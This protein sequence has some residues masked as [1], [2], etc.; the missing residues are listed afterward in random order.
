MGNVPEIS[1]KPLV[2]AFAVAVESGR[3]NNEDVG[4]RFPSIKKPGAA[5]D[6]G[7]LVALRGQ[8]E[9]F[10]KLTKLILQNKRSFSALAR[11]QAPLRNC[12]VNLGAA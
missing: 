4:H 9:G 12:F 2:L 5:S 8:R 3:H 1:V 10:Q 7:G 6:R 11:L